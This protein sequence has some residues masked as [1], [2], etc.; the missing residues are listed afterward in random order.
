MIVNNATLNTQNNT[1]CAVTANGTGNANV[2]FLINTPTNVFTKTLCLEKITK[3]IA[4]FKIAPVVRVVNPGVIKVCVGQTIN[5]ENLS[6]ANGGSDLVAY[7]W[8]FDDNRSSTSTAF[9]PSYVYSQEGTFTITLTVKNAC[10]CITTFKKTVQVYGAGFDITCPTVICENQKQDY[11]LPREIANSCQFDKKN[12]SVIGGQI[13][14]MT[15]ESAEVVWNN[16]DNDGFGYLT[17]TPKTCDISCLQPTTIKVPVIKNIGAIKGPTSICVGQQIKYSLPQWPTTDFE[18]AVERNP[19]NVLA[20]VIVTDQRNEIIIEPLSN[21]GFITLTVTYK[22][23]LLHCGGTA[24]LKIFIKDPVDITGNAIICQHESNTYSTASATPVNWQL[25]QGASVIATVNNAVNFSYSFPLFGNFILKASGAAVC[26]TNFNITVVKAPLAPTNIVGDTEICPNAPYS[27]TVFGIGSDNINYK[28]QITGGIFIGSNTGQNVNVSFNNI[29]PYNI[30]AAAVTIA[31]AECT[32]A[33]TSLL[34]TRKN[35]LAQ[36]SNNNTQVCANTVKTYQINQLNTNNL[37]NDFDNIVWTVSNPSVGSISGGQNTNAVTVTW[38]NTTITTTVNLI[39]TVTKCS[40]TETFALPIT[41]QGIPQLAIAALPS[42]CSGAATLFQLSSSN[43]NLNPNSVVNW[44]FGG[45]Q[46]TG[47][48]NQYYTFNNFGTANSNFTVTAVIANPNGCLSTSTT[49]NLTITVLPTPAISASITGNG[50]VFCDT[51]E[52]NTSLTASAGANAFIQWYLND[53]LIPNDFGGNAT[54]IQIDSN[55][56]FGVY[57]FTASYPNGCS[58]ASN[59]I[60]IIQNCPNTIVCTNPAN[61]II[62]NTS[63]NNCGIVT[64]SGN[65]SITPISNLFD[66]FGPTNFSNVAQPFSFNAQVGLYTVIYRPSYNCSNNI[67]IKFPKIKEVLVPYLPKLSYNAI[68]NG[69]NSFNVTLTDITTYYSALSSSSYIFQYKLTSSNTWLPITGNQ[70]NSL[71]AGNY[72]FKVIVN[73]SFNGTPQPACETIVNANLQTVPTVIINVEQNPIPCHDAPVRFNIIGFLDDSFKVLWDFDDNG[74]QNTLRDV[75]RVFTTPGLHNITLTVTSPEGCSRT[76]TRPITVPQPCFQGT[77][78][79]IPPN[80]TVCKGQ[81]VT[82][83][84]TPNTTDLC[85]PNTYEWYNGNVL[86]GTTPTIN[87]TN[88]GFYWV[89]VSSDLNC[90]YKTPNRI[91]PVFN[92]LPTIKI[93]APNSICL[94]E[95]AIVKV[96]SNAST[97]TWQVNNVP[98][99]QYSNNFNPTFSG[100]PQGENNVSITASLNGCSSTQII[101]IVVSLPPTILPITVDFVGCNPYRYRLT[102]N[103]VGSASIPVY[104]WSNGATTRSIIITSGGPYKVTASIGNCSVS[105]QVDVPKSPESF[106]WIF[107]TGCYTDC[108]TIKKENYLIGPNLPLSNWQWQT[109]GVAAPNEGTGFAPNFTLDGSASYNLAINTGHCASTSKPLEYT[110]TACEPCNIAEP[111]ISQIVTMLEP[112]CKHQITMSI[113][114]GQSNSFVAS[115][116]DISNNVLITPAT[117]TVLPGNN[118]YTFTVIPLQN[119]N[120]GYITLELQ[121]APYYDASQQICR[122]VSEVYIPPCGISEGGSKVSSSIKNEKQVLPNFAFKLY[123]N[124]AK[125]MVSISYSLNEKA[126]ISLYDLSGRLL[127]QHTTQNIQ[128]EWQCNTSQMPAG[129]YIVVVQNKNG[130][131]WQEKLIIQ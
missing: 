8:T 46:F 129:V 108:S 99:P 9:E 59:I 22:N 77:V 82:L 76:F 69:N 119:F 107:P 79:A 124:P 106:L 42:I 4:D 36:I 101:K 91:T 80:A 39:A 50:N 18:W 40:I 110:T 68:C 117:I 112:F 53:E 51:A 43:V 45:N 7:E 85:A 90:D 75:R 58:I 3:P 126:N 30:S 86:I 67:P 65:T 70:L 113:N 122:S 12:W 1:T 13:T 56:G 116:S 37:F 100:L 104:N 54:T 102:A 105:T 120:G 16:V 118:N 98:Q 84:Y 15:Q 66:I 73:G 93:I 72:Q 130:K 62:N 10:N 28:W 31:P 125:E 55:L 121:S 32:S 2:T 17:F 81:P 48:L 74:A 33:Y 49:A 21:V 11:F 61:P 94:G 111:I 83:Q 87:V 64:I 128:G 34:L 14:N 114:S 41:V 95:N 29:G 123:P 89:K 131:V 88:N 38:N 19:G 71:P 97:C 109:N 115:L 20:N 5:F 96:V 26:P 44:N 27:Y 23:T 6:S 127:Q 103:V 24:K 57:N 47:N 63:S 35:V 78:T 60:D 92:P 25:V 52:I